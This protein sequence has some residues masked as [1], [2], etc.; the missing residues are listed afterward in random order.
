MIK[1]LLALS[2]ICF[3]FA[4]GNNTTK[5]ES[6]PVA[7][8]KHCYVYNDTSNVITLTAIYAKD[9]VSGTLAYDIDKKDKNIGTFAGTVKGDM[10]VADYTFMSEGKTSV[11][12]VAFKKSGSSLVGAMGEMEEKDGKMVFKS[13]N[14]LDFNHAIIL[15]ETD[16]NK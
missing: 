9:S 14:G 6:K 16:C 12:Q 13:M 15:T 10:I 4:C 5:D 11:R 7:I 8:D 3:L 1:H 2:S